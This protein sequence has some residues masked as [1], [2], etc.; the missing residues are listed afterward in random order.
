M[1]VWARGAGP[2]LELPARSLVVD[3][4]FNTRRDVALCSC[5]RTVA[6]GIAQTQPGNTRMGCRL[7]CLSSVVK[8][9][10]RARTHCLSGFLWMH[11]LSWVCAVGR[12]WRRGSAP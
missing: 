9:G 1:R 6:F 8:D 11:M 10:V 3:T 2:T 7:R 5:S 4:A 12:V